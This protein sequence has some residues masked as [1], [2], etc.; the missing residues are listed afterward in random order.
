MVEYV[1]LVN[2]EICLIIS[3]SDMERR[4]VDDDKW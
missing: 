4:A 2:W 1:P 3:A